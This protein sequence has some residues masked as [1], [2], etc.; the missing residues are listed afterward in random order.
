MPPFPPQPTVAEESRIPEILPHRAPFLFV[1]RIIGFRAH[2]YITAETYL[3]PDA[4]F[5]AG[6]FPGYPVMPGVLIT[7]ALAQTSGLL[8]GLSNDMPSTL[9][10][11][12]GARLFL[13]SVNVK[14]ISPAKPGDTLILTAH[15]MKSYG[16]LYRF[17]VKA[18][19]GEAETAKGSLT[20]GKPG[21][22]SL[23][24]QE[25]RKDTGEMS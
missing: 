12:Q 16:A 2:A 5:F 23:A 1:D 13:A 22:V 8:I 3:S 24:A 14:F 15:W 6:H 4:A 10:A 7:E 21:P 11:K 19:V 18:T 25:K 9:H 17:D 20:L